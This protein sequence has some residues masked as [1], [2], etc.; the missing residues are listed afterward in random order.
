MDNLPHV[1]LLLLIL[2]RF[3]DTKWGHFAECS[4]SGVKMQE[5]NGVLVASFTPGGGDCQDKEIVFYPED[6]RIRLAPTLIGRGTSVIGGRRG[7]AS[8]TTQPG[9][10]R[11]LQDGNDVVVK[12]YWPEEARMSEVEILKK[13]EEYS[14]KINP[15][16]SHIPEMICYRD[17]K[18][19]CSSTKRIRKF[20]GLPTGGCRRLQIIA[21]RR[22]RSI[23]ELK[24]A[25]MLAAYLECFFC[26]HKKIPPT[27][28]V[29]NVFVVINL[30]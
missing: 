10:R 5:K 12:M 6:D 3:D 27:H 7:P 1:L 20:L 23:K 21:F 30:M 18:F 24:E 25:D 4:Q 29:A 17:P 26:E 14:E 9:D 8:A 19:V 2:Q 28:Y 11:E 16:K 13:A 22:L 15:I